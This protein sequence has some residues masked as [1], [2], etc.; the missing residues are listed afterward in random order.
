MG[1]GTALKHL[2]DAGQGD[3]KTSTEA[4][5]FGSQGCNIFTMVDSEISMGHRNA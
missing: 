3:V 1:G 4:G 2:P 5:D